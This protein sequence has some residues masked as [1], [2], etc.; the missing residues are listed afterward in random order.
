ML[1][2][3]KSYFKGMLSLLMEASSAQTDSPLPRQ[4][5][6]LCLLGKCMLYVYVMF[7]NTSTVLV[8][9]STA[10]GTSMRKGFQLQAPLTHDHF[11]K[12]MRI[13]VWVQAIQ[14][15]MMLQRAVTYLLGK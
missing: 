15:Q 9:S 2:P 13:R 7:I 8:A 6:L 14:P 3:A 11:H 10:N 4:L 1:S 12:C 5:Q